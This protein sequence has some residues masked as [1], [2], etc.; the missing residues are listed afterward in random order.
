MIDPSASTASQASQFADI[1]TR[2]SIF[3]QPAQILSRYGRAI[4]GYLCALLGDEDGEEMAR[5]FAVKVLQGALEA[6]PPGRGRFRDY[7][8]TCVHHAAMDFLRRSQRRGGEKSFEDLSWIADPS[9]EPARARETWLSLYRAEVLASALKALQHYQ[10]G[11][12]GN[13]F[14]TLVGLLDRCDDSEELAR[15][16][17]KMTG[18]VYTAANA[19]KQKERARRKLAELLLEE[20]RQTLDEPTPQALQE[21]LGTLGLLDQVRPFLPEDWR[22]H[23][24]QGTLPAHVE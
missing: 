8:K 11:N 14:H 6:R 5:E 4:R 3:T 17:S 21:E 12:P 9:A 22:T 2:M 13:V 1:A 7:L 18:T 23:G 19:R 24:T 16:L 10:E 15:E 20:I